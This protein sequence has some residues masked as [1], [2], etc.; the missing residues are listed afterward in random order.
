MSAGDLG[1][2]PSMTASQMCDMEAT[3]LLAMSLRILMRK[4]GI[5]VLA[6]AP[7]SVS[8]AHE[9]LRQDKGKGSHHVCLRDS[10][11]RW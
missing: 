10:K 11:E 6:V 9:K 2:D 4:V 7:E 5:M 3:T 8:R 1:P